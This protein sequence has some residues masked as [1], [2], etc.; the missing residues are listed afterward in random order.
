MNDARHNKDTEINSVID[1]RNRKVKL[2]VDERDHIIME[3]PVMGRN[4]TAIY[5]TIQSPKAIYDSGECDNREVYFKKSE[6]ATYGTKYYT[7]AIVE[8]DAT[9]K[10]GYIVTAF[11]HEKEGGNIGERTYPDD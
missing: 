1:P 3:H 7:K 5:D 11:P 2:Y 4:F 8:F 10:E 9:R 6:L